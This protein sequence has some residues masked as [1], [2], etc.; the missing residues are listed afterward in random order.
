MR[1]YT[2]YYAKY[3]GDKGVQISNSKPSSY[4]VVLPLK[5]LAPDWNMVEYWKEKMHTPERDEAW[6]KF[7]DSYWK[8][9]DDIGERKILEY[10]HDGM[11]LLC[12][13]KNYDECHR[14]ILANWLQ[15]HG[16][17]VVELGRS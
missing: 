12:W 16:V 11:V 6:G 7:V 8:K 9:L 1:L 2:S 13:C 4:D 10:L 17:D 14:S 3:K 15:C 5:W